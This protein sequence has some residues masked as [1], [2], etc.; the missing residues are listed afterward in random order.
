[1]KRETSNY[2]KHGYRTIAEG[3]DA[4]FAGEYAKNYT[5]P[6][7]E[8]YPPKGGLKLIGGVLSNYKSNN[9][10]F[11]KV[12]R[13]L[14]A[15]KKLLNNFINDEL[16]NYTVIH[17]SYLMFNHKSNKHYG[18]YF[19]FV[20]PKQPT[21]TIMGSADP[22]HGIPAKPLTLDA[23][24]AYVITDIE[25]LK[26][27]IKQD[28]ASTEFIRQQ[29]RTE[30]VPS[31]AMAQNGGI[32]GVNNM[33]AGYFTIK[34]LN[35]K[36]KLTP[37]GSLYIV[38]RYNL[39]NPARASYV[40][41]S[42][43]NNRPD[44]SPES[45]GERTETIRESDIAS[46]QLIGMVLDEA[47]RQR[48]NANELT[49]IRHTPVNISP[50][51]TKNG[52][53]TIPKPPLDAV[54]KDNANPN[55]NKADTLTRKYRNLDALTQDGGLYMT[56][57]DNPTFFDQM[58]VSGIEYQDRHRLW[59]LARSAS[60]RA[61]G[62]LHRYLQTH[63]STPSKVPIKDIA[64]YSGYYKQKMANRK[65]GLLKKRDKD[66]LLADLTM[67]MS[68]TTYYSYFDKVNQVEALT[69]TKIFSFSLSQD[70]KYILNLSYTDEYL[71][72]QDGR[73]AML[74]VPA[75]IELDT[76][77]Q[78]AYYT[79]QYINASFTGR[80]RHGETSIDAE[81][82]RLRVLN[83]AKYAGYKVDT[84][85]NRQKAKNSVIS[86][87]NDILACK[88]DLGR[89]VVIQK[90]EIVDE[91]ATASNLEVMLYPAQ[92]HI[93]KALKSP[94]QGKALKEAKRRHIKSKQ[95]DLM[96]LVKLVRNDGINAY[97]KRNAEQR[98][99][100]ELGISLD[101]LNSYLAKNRPVEAP[102]N[103]HDKV[104]KLIKKYE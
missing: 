38:K 47:Y 4:V 6:V 42:A 13:K 26:E 5:E 81:P 92:E 96:T 88:D 79:A 94:A 83:I 87:L 9:E 49:N 54:L 67:L 2:T 39:D 66:E 58:G 30:L 17:T 32:D 44:P 77:K 15:N 31:G 23:V 91:T 69:S 19:K 85:Q 64:K 43:P 84:K 68:A 71:R 72:A 55:P 56:L 61:S 65:D 46:L 21:L 28:L 50:E 48:A 80:N 24:G 3:V 104:I 51:Y 60:G 25:G 62:M 22:E 59:L 35:T 57:D 102:D 76:L 10:L 16:S 93:V 34:L 103:L 73:N 36:I 11:T 100:D 82:L 18:K 95:Q 41:Y 40:T 1:M 52:G 78:G 8:L 89:N 29:A 63:K 101:K 90:Y 70:G 45:D 75:P 12:A 7:K 14:V 99:A 74:H 53:T 98:V 97:D 20:E 27:A 86:N 37:E 33:L